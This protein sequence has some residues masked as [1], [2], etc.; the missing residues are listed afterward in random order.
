MIESPLLQEMMA[1][2][3]AETL[4]EAILGFLADRFGTVPDEMA[5]AVRTIHEQSKLKK[6]LREAAYCPDLEAFRRRLGR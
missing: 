4:H 3:A 2:N 6:L 1:K 5:A